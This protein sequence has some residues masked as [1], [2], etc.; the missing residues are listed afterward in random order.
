MG[1]R[2]VGDSV[3]PF[4]A[5]DLVLV[6]AYLPHLWRNDISYA[7]N[8]NSG[9]VQTIVIKFLENFIGDNTLDNPSFLK[10][11]QLLDNSKYGIRFNSSVSHQLH[12]ELMAIV[13]L[14]VA[15]QAISLLSILNC[16]SISKNFKVLS[17]TDMRQYA[18][19]SN[20]DID[21]VPKIYF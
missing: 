11:R 21:T 17:S 2:F 18:I 13:D 7:Q 3:A 14:P 20:H 1:M 19:E 9:G 15:D 8:E 6:G 10:I 16:L 12:E 4:A 5:G